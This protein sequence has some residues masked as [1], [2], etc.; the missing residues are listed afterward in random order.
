MMF[1]ERK[2]ESKG[3]G[4]VADSRYVLVTPARNEERFISRTIE[5]VVAQTM[6]PKRWVV[7]SDGSTDRTDEI[8]REAARRHDFIRF[9][10]READG[11]RS[12]GSKVRAFRMSEKELADVDYDVY[13]QPRCG[14]VIAP[15]YYE[16]VL[17]YLETHTLNWHRGRGGRGIGQRAL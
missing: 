17:R 5:A 12:F 3:G 6:R 4:T 16:S 14:R 7:V 11:K 15:D 9:V 1:S 8:L 2:A 13:W 10:R